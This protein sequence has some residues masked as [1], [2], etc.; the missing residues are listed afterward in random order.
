M[1]GTSDNYFTMQGFGNPVSASGQGE[2]AGPQASSSSDCS[3]LEVGNLATGEYTITRSNSHLCNKSPDSFCYICGEY[4]LE[5]NRRSLSDKIKQ[6]YE[7]CFGLQITNLDSA[8]VP[9]TICS[10]CNMMLIRWKKNKKQENLKFTIPMI[11]SS[12]TGLQNCYFCMTDTSGFTWNTKKKIVYA[13]VSSAIKPQKIEFVKEVN[14]VEEMDVEEDDTLVEESSE[15]D[16]SEDEEYLPG[17]KTKDP[18]TLSREELNDLVRDLA[19]PKDGAELLASR[20]KEK[21]FLAKGVSVTFYR[22][23]EKKFRKFFM[24]DD[25]NSVVYCSDVKAL[26]DELKPNTYKDDEWRLFIDSSKRSLKAVLLHIGNEFAP[27]PIAHSTKLKETYENLQI[28]LGK[29]KYSEHN[30]KICG[31]LKIATLFLGQQSGFTKY[32]CYLCLFDS[33]DRKNHYVKK[34]WPSRSSLN[35]GSHNVIRPPLIQSSKYLLPP[36]HI[37]LGLIKQYVKALN[38][39]GDCFAYLTEKFPAINDAKLKEGIFDGPQIRSLCQDANFEETM[40]DTEKAAW[41]L[42]LT[43]SLKI[44][45]TIV[46]N[47]ENVFTKT[48]V[49]WRIDTKEIGVLT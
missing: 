5:R 29:M 8:W 35:P 14:T 28:V 30:W 33:R 13:N 38:K 25:Q 21:H 10:R 47:R 11:W 23:R 9:H 17:G 2:K 41:I 22:N 49:K 31:D 32:P 42:I 15:E 45:E 4:N 39:D 44:V 18:E 3:S 48:S 36:L 46:K 19:L 26:V 20:L 6:I 24:N 12:P 27:I 40:N 37:K 7:E 1:A 43:T 34:D 16:H